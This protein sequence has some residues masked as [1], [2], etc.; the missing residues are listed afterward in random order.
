MQ[1]KARQMGIDPYVYFAGF[2]PPQRTVKYI[3][4]SEVCVAPFERRYER[5]ELAPLKLYTYMACGRPVVIS[6]MTEVCEDLS[7]AVS[8]V[9]PEEPDALA[10]AIIKLLDHPEE[11]KSMGKNG[12]VIVERRYA[13]DIIATHCK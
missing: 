1:E 11:A 10:E 12:R 4:A 6:G 13:W 5:V 7:G 3:T 8:I 9:P 2:E